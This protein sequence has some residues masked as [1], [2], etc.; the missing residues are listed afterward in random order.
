MTLQ[1]RLL[2]VDEWWKL[3]DREPF[4]SA[5]V[6]TASEHWIIPVVEIDGRIVA[7]CAIFDTVH[8][9]GFQVDGDATRNPAIFRQLLELSLQTLQEYKVDGA[10]VTV[11]HDRPDLQAMVEQFGFIPAPGVLY[12]LPV[13]PR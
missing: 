8:W 5:G 2:P 3:A 10:H 13:K 11:P 12:I 4:A 7:S 6:P 1:A 9:D